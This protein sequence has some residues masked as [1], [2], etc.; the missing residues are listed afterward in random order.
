M[1]Q[2]SAS[3]LSALLLLAVLGLGVGGCVQ[4][5][6]DK[7]DQPPAATSQRSTSNGAQF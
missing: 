7:P 4:D 1:T 2:S 6:A 3:R 5:D